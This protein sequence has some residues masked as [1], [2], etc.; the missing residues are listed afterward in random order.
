MTKY[1]VMEELEESNVAIPKRI[2]S[3]EEAALK[4]CDE[5]ENKNENF[6]YWVYQCEEDDS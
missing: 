4:L 3:T 6:I 2:L 1:I 5:L